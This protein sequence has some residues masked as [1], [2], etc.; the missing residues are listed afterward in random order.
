MFWVPFSVAVGHESFLN[1]DLYIQLS[2]R[3]SSEG[4]GGLSFSKCQMAKV[5]YVKSFLDQVSRVIVPSSCPVFP[6]IQHEAG[7]LQ[8]VLTIIYHI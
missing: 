4:N 2:C 8:I 1:A 7:P 6:I 3:I 5:K